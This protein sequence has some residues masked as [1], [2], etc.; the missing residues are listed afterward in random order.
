[1]QVLT[2]GGSWLLASPSDFF[3]FLYTADR[4][5]R[6]AQFFQ[7]ASTSTVRIDNLVPESPYTLCA[8]LI[9]S[10]S[11]VSS[12]ACLDLYTMTWGTVHKATLSFSKTLT[13]QELNNV[14]C[15][16]TAI[17]GTNQLYLAD[18]EGNSCGNRSVANANYVYNGSSFT[19]ETQGTIIY[20]FTNPSLTG[21][22]PA[23]LA[24]TNLFGSD[25]QLSVASVASAQSMFSITYMTATYVTSFNARTMTASTTASSLSV[26]YSTPS[27]NPVTLQL[28]ISNVQIVGGEGT[29][30][31]VLVHYK[32][33]IVDSNSGST[34]VNIRLNQAPS[35]EQVLNCQNWLSETA[36][37]C[38]RAVYTGVSP[39]S[40]V[41]AAIQPNSLYMLYYVVA[42]E[43]PLRPV[44]STTVSEDTVVTYI[45][46]P[47][48]Q[49]G[50]V[51]L[52]LLLMMI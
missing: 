46:E 36:E 25:N 26:H 2:K 9:N 35:V 19:T 8:Y 39:L 18:S 43:F 31:F 7:T 50:L 41:F 42:S 44:T 21:S 49:L 28:A 24:F 23:P 48:L 38:G 33:I 37:G 13:A 1:M 29:V 22:D 17:S 20:L 15:Y 16:F 3:S 34:T 10:F 5:Q 51:T 30:Y 45:W 14:I 11:V 4:D 6:L 12:V 40:L 32:T 47:W 52:L 27:Y